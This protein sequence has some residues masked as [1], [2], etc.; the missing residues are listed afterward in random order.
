MKAIV[1]V[2]VVHR[3]IIK[4]KLV[5]A[6]FLVIT[7][8]AFTKHIELGTMCSHF[9]AVIAIIAFIDLIKSLQWQLSE[10]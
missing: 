7:V 10:F 3:H 5:P 1:W 4:V 8:T 9:P 6:I 2:A